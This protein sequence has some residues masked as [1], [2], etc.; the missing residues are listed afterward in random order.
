VKE[1]RDPALPTPP[2]YN[3]KQIFASR[4]RIIEEGFSDF[5]G[6]TPTG[7]CFNDLVRQ[8]A[9]QLPD[10]KVHVVY[11]SLTH[12]AGV[13]LTPQLI[14]ETAW[15]LAGNKQR[16]GKGYPV[17]PWTA[18]QSQEWVPVQVVDFEAK[19]S[20][21]GKPGVLYRLRVLAG[22]PTPMLLSKWWPR[23]FCYSLARRMG[24][25]WSRH[26]LPYKHP[27][28]LVRLRMLILLDPLY[29]KYDAL[30]FK[31]VECPSGLKAWNR[32]LI[33]MRNRKQGKGVWACPMGFQHHCHQCPVGYDRCPAGEHPITIQE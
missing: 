13:T 27:S 4:N 6:Y 28:D 11:D 3:L 15:R 31:H 22:T 26:G 33:E 14:K 1:K 32:P 8:V 29:S 17:P 19:D 23:G 2:A 12:L 7:D 20:A 16:L 5:L 21:K 10:V 9:R 30:D 24:F 18:Q 25:T